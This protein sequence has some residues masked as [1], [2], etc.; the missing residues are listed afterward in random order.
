[1]ELDDIASMASNKE[2]TDNGKE[3]M[4]E[5]GVGP[6]TDTAKGKEL[7]DGP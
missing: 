3:E 7:F 4:E 5:E 1:M 6:T 2:N